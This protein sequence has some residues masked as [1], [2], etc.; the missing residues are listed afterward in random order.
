[1]KITKAEKIIEKIPFYFFKLSCFFSLF[2]NPLLQD[3]EA[4]SVDKVAL[5]SDPES[6]S[7]MFWVQYNDDGSSQIYHSFKSLE[8]EAWDEPLLVSDINVNVTSAMQVQKD[9]AGNILVVWIGVNSN[10]GNNCLYCNVYL[11][12][13]QA[14]A[15]PAL[16]SDTGQNLTTSFSLNVNSL[17]NSLEI[18][19]SVYDENFNTNIFSRRLLLGEAW[20]PIL[21]VNF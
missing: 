6:N 3:L 7:L 13:N 21:Q 18:S 15:G 16:I 4:L 11:A 10:F 1:M 2:F 8:G 19:W 20:G 12:A 17:N 9:D 14:W 5:I